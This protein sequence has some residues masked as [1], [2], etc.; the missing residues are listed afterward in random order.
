MIVL[1]IIII[2]L[3]YSIENYAATKNVQYF[4]ANNPDI[5]V[6][7]KHIPTNAKPCFNIYLGSTPLAT[8]KALVDVGSKNAQFP[9]IDVKYI[10]PMG[11]RFNAFVILITIG[12]EI[13]HAAL[14]LDILDNT[15]DS[16]IKTPAKIIVE[17][18]PELVTILA[19][20]SDAPESVINTP[21][22]S[23][24]ANV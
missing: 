17:D 18:I 4:R 9:P 2:L 13:A 24:P 16:N 1:I 21:I 12:I 19:I 7:T 20:I 5:N 23:P 11:L 6:I 22:A 15:V 10:Y 3:I 8:G 14:L